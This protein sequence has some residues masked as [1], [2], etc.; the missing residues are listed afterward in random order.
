[1]KRLLTTTL[2]LLAAAS[3]FAAKPLKVSKGS[4]D[5][6]RQDATATWTID[7][8]Q[9]T[10]E[11]KQSFEAWCESD[12][13]TRV[14]SMNDTFFESFNNYSKGLKLVNEEPAPYK[15]VFTVSDFEQKQGPGMWGSMFIRVSGVIDIVDCSSG[16]TVCELEV[17]GVKGDTDFVQNDRFP[18]TMD[19]LCRDIF[20][21]K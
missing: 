14:Q 21:L 15:L 5:V 16:E 3:L 10:F 9:A 8:S 17:N 20:K 4:L 7:L 12:Y 1:M 18:K 19:W 6:V 2:L 13:Q 11:K